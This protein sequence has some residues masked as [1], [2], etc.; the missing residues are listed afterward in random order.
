MEIFIELKSLLFSGPTKSLH[1]RPDEFFVVLANHLKDI[2]HVSFR[3]VAYL[4]NKLVLSV[5]LRFF[6][7]PSSLLSSAIKLF[8]SKSV[9]LKNKCRGSI[10]T[11][12]WGMIGK[13]G[14]DKYPY[15]LLIN[16]LRTLPLYGNLEKPQ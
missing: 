8:V 14:F 5:C 1:S 13:S 9:I 3:N 11:F 2:L 12:L 15:F 10:I 6:R 4:Y 7:P 16:P